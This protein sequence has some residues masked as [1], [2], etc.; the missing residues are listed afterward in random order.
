MVH[1]V[2]EKTLTLHVGNIA[3][4]NYVLIITIVLVSHNTAAP[5]FANSDVPFVIMIANAAR[6]KC[7]VVS[8]FILKVTVLNLV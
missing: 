7:V 1:Q 6:M 3:L 2:S 8:I 5:G 4:V